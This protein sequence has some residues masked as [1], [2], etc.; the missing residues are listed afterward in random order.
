MHASIE[1][2][3]NRR[4][5]IKDAKVIMEVPDASILVDEE[6]GTVFFRYRGA[7]IAFYPKA[8]LWSA[9]LDFSEWEGK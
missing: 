1:T 5:D 4:F 2:T 6:T 7:G 9:P 3:M 8:G